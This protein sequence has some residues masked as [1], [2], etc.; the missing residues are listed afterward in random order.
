VNAAALQVAACRD[1]GVGKR[2]SLLRRGEP[3]LI[4]LGI[5]EIEG[6]RGGQPLIELLELTVIKKQ[7]ESGAGVD[8]F[9]MTALG[10]NLEIVLQSF[11]P[12]DL[13]AVVAFKPQA[14]CF[15]TALAF[16]GFERRF[17]SCKPSHADFSVA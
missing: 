1:D 3:L 6:I 12:D 17:L 13:A 8:P 15:D 2:G 7:H 10:A 4:A 5:C 16:L 11:P 9:M 14:L